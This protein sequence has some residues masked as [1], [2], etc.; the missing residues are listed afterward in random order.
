MPKNYNKNATSSKSVA[1]NPVPKPASSIISAVVK[2][3]Y[4]VIVFVD[5]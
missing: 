4:A 1:Q 3:D 2:A 5:R